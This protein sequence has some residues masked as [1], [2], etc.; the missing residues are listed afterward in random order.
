MLSRTST[1]PEQVGRQAL[2]S[3]PSSEQFLNW[4]S[5]RSREPSGDLAG[6][7][8]GQLAKE[9]WKTFYTCLPRGYMYN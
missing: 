8:E 6:S 7:I 5:P 4:N 9:P 1:K 2:A 3:R